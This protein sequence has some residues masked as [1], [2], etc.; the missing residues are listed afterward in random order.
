[1]I[2]VNI[3]EAKTHLSSLLARVAAGEEVTI[4][5]SGKPVAKL[6]SIESSQKKRVGGFA[7]GKIQI[8]D[9]FDDEDPK[10]NRMF[11]S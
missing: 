4:A 5:K 9:D 7:R 6:T 2:S 3:H 8:P 1:M 11:Y 10:I